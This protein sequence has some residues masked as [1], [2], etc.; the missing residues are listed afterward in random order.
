M[1]ATSKECSDLGGIE[2]LLLCSDRK[3]RR[4][5]PL[6]L[7]EEC[8]IRFINLSERINDPFSLLWLCVGL[9]QV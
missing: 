3:A 8:D 1:P 2:T 7:E 9:L 5:S 6:F 4:V